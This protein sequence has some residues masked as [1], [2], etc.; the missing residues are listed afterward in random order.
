MEVLVKYEL[1]DNAI[2]DAV[3]I[4]ISNTLED[5]VEDPDW[6][7][8]ITI[9]AVCREV[10]NIIEEDEG[11]EFAPNFLTNFYPMIE[12]EVRKQFK[13]IVAFMRGE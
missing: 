1:S 3:N 2:K 4:A 9:E 10:I 12:D 8:K 7:S 6:T 13:G 5:V 11:I